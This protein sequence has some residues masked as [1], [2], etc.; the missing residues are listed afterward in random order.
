M[1]EVI[2]AEVIAAERNLSLVDGE[3]RADRELADGVL[4]SGAEEQ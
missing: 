4:D 2:E 3:E 1:P